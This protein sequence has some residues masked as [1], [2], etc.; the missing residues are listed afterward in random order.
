VRGRLLTV[1]QIVIYGQL[2]LLALLV[3]LRFRERK[4]L[5]WMF[6]FLLSATLWVSL[7]QTLFPWLLDWPAAAAFYGPTFHSI[8][9]IAL[10]FL[11]LYLL[12]LDQYP[13]LLKWTKVLAWI[14]LCS[15]I[16]DGLV[17]YM[18]HRD[19]H[20]LLF[21]LLDAIATIGFSTPA[22]FPFILIAL[23][24]RKKMD[25]ARRFVA[26]AA[27][28]S[29]MYFVVHHTAV[30]GQRF[31]LLRFGDP[32]MNPMFRIGGVEVSIPA[33]LSLVLVYA[34]VYALYRYMVEQGQRQGVMLQEYRNARAVQQV[35]IPEN[36]PDIPGYAIQSVYK[37]YGEVGGDFFQIMPL[38]EGG[39]M[40]V[41]GD[42]SGKGMPAAM[43]VSLL[44]GTIRTLAHYTQR[45]GAMMAAMNQ[46]LIGR[47]H[48][49]FTTCLVLR[50]DPD[51]TLTIANAGHISPYLGGK[52]LALDTGLPLGIA[53]SPA[54]E[55]TTFQFAVGE[56]LTL[57]TDGVVE[58]RDVSGTLLGF[59]RTAALSVQ[60][61]EAVAATAQ[62]FGQDDDITVLTL[63]RSSYADG[64]PARTAGGFAW[65]T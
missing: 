30:Q 59:E 41:I 11:L 60:S 34:I 10:W 8:E 62:G 40:V 55:E 18:P 63:T 56:Q 3:W 39:V 45:P 21:E 6:A 13:A 53:W 58:A 20:A 50:A 25:P 44:V 9:D 14:T 1:A 19:A 29:D 15:A 17:F 33:V 5:F 27:F 51:G 23:A 61:A 48:G 7:D 54:Y 28:L 2:T 37:P 52:E 31:T 36:A 38:A 16:A 43:T 24:L 12:E 46:R 32:M 47:S 4:V 57:V 35:L 42:V 26:I 22:V 65:R 64:G 49:G